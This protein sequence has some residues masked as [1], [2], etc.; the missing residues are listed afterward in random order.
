M[1]AFGANVR[2]AHVVEKPVR[3]LAFTASLRCEN[4][5]RHTRQSFAVASADIRRRLMTV[6]TPAQG[7]AHVRALEHGAANFSSRNGAR[8]AAVRGTSIANTD[9]EKEGS[10]M[11]KSMFWCSLI[12]A[13]L[14]SSACKKEPS[15][16]AGEQVRKAVEE[17][18]EQRKD[19]R[20]E[21]KDLTK[22]QRELAQAQGDLAKARANFM[23]TTRERLAKLDAK[24]NELEARADAKARSAAVELR[25]RRNILAAK[26]DTAESR[27]EA[28]W[29]QFRTDVDDSF[30]KVEKEIKDVLD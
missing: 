11:R 10:I 28:D 2:N 8:R 30:K 15:Q 14:F 1:Y 7:R 26:L 20:E 19:V 12:T 27:I 4:D 18:N 16:K 24:L 9:R 29:D 21:Q 17:V 25:A 6:R 23:T 22:Q 13:A 5:V 3:A